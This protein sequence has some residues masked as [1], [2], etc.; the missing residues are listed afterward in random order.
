LD[1]GFNPGL[2]ANNKVLAVACQ[3]DGRIFIGGTFTSVN[4]RLR[5]GLARLN[6]DGS[7]DAGFA[8]RLD[9]V[10]VRALQFL[11]AGKLL[12]GGRYQDNEG[13]IRGGVAQIDLNGIVNLVFSLMFNPG[14]WVGSLAVQ[15]GGKIWVGGSFTNVGNL[16]RNNLARLNADGSVD[17]GVLAE[18]G[19]NGY[20]YSMAADST[21]HLLIS[22]AFTQV[23]GRPRAYVARLN[24]DGSL[25]STFVPGWD[26]TSV[27]WE[28]HAGLISPMAIAVQPDGRIWLGGAFSRKNPVLNH[29]IR[30]NADGS[31]DTSLKPGSGANDWICAMALQADWRPLIAGIFDTFDGM[32]QSGIARLN[33]NDPIIVGNP[34]DQTARVGRMALT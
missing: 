9:A 23:N 25:D 4:G 28:E 17:Q 24:S 27:K 14:S 31:V 22:G 18:T 8:P 7:L 6:Q 20:V 13:T 12:A 11:P 19:A 15:P 32:S 29:L 2:G 26:S 21:G 16:A 1:A 5:G 3:S 34:V 33:G 10:D 30:L